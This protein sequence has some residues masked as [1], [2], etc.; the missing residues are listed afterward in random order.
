[1]TEEILSAQGLSWTQLGVAG[2]ILTVLLWQGYRWMLFPIPT[3][4]KALLLTCRIV[5]TLL[6]LWCVW[7]PVLQKTQTHK[8][9]I[10]PKVITIVDQ[11]SSMSFKDDTT[12]R[13][14]RLRS[15]LDKLK[16]TLAESE[17]KDSV[18]LGIGSSMRPLSYPPVFQDKQSLILKNL[19]EAAE[20]YTDPLNRR[21]RYN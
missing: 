3:S 4:R 9:T 10:L 1:M 17:V 14:D 20:Q 2:V 11:S 19:Q 18:S 8:R 13:E 12:Q 7:D 5:W 21:T 6:L 15:V 16:A